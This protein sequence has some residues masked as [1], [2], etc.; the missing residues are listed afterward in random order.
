[1]IDLDIDWLIKIHI[2]RGV[3][4]RLDIH[5]LDD[6]LDEDSLYSESIIYED[7]SSDTWTDMDFVRVK[8]DWHEDWCV[9]EDFDWCSDEID[10]VGSVVVGIPY[11]TLN[12]TVWVLMSYW[13]GLSDVEA[14]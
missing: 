12:Y 2:L 3:L 5:V 13:C 14:S 11:F 1:M 9:S 4:I 6:K 8:I 7:W 10:V